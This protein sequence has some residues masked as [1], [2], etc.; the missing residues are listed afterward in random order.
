LT[1]REGLLYATNGSI[2]CQTNANFPD[3]LKVLTHRDVRK[4]VRDQKTAICPVT[5]ATEIRA[6]LGG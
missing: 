1:L 3:S 2:L 5:S 4:K 6:V